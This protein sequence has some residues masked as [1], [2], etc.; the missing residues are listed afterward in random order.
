MG[1]DL[2]D[3]VYNRKLDC[4]D[5]LFDVDDGYAGCIEVVHGVEKLLELIEEDTE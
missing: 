2:A 4:L 1:F 5:F 3:I